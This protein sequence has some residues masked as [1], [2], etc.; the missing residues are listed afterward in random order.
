MYDIMLYEMISYSTI[1][2]FRII[3]YFICCFGLPCSK[4]SREAG[5]SRSH[6]PQAASRCRIF[7]RC[8]EVQGEIQIE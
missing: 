4:A 5:G 6:Q 7:G 3:S 1:S 2:C 8:L